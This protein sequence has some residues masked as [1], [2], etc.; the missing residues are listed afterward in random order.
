MTPEWTFTGT[1][2]HRTDGQTKKGND[3]INLV[4]S[5]DD[6]YGPVLCVCTHFGPLPPDVATGATVTADGYMSGRAGT[7]AYAGKFYAGLRATR[8][9]LHGHESAGSSAPAEQANARPAVQS[10]PSD[11]LPF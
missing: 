9:Y 6:K 8:V 2:T 7:G 10:D 4:I 3:M 11:Q 1:L 5:R